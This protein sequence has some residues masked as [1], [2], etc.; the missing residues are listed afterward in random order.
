M[1]P[2]R[3]M[4]HVVT[5][6]EENIERPIIVLKESNESDRRSERDNGKSIYLL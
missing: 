2:Q 4:Q 6:S 5:D 1:R 3:E